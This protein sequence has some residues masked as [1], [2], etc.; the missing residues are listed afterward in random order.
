MIPWLILAAS[1]QSTPETA[2]PGSRWLVEIEETTPSPLEL[3]AEENYS[4]RTRALQMQSVLACPKA[5]PLGKN[6][7]VEC[8]FE[9]VALRATPRS[10]DPGEALNPHNPEVLTNMVGRLA[11]TRVVFVMSPDGRVVTVD[12]PD[13]EVGNRRESESRETLRCLAFDVVSSFHL[14]RPEDWK[15]GWTE[16]NS[17]LLR[18]PTRPASSGMSKTEHSVSQIEGQTVIQSTG[19]GT[20]TSPYEPWEFN[21]NGKI[22]SF[23]NT[24]TGQGKG[25]GGGLGPV[26]TANPTAANDGRSTGSQPAATTPTD[27]TFAG[28]MSSVTVFD[29]ATGL[30]AERVWATLGTPTASSL[31]N[32]QGL[33]VYYAGRLKRLGP[34]EAAALGATEVVAPPGSKLEGIGIWV[35]LTTL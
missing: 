6:L 22:T 31:G 17:L 26:G 15:G 23:G 5:T 32:M 33:S 11:G 27:Y 19:S 34:T 18:A 16:K 28:T 30:P 3:S 7:E 14:K 35:P 10:L 12:L 8:R 13:I 4:F 1:A 21:Y 2:W 25:G 29:P 24:G 20:F 9:S